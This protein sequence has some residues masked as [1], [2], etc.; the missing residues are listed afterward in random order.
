MIARDDANKDENDELDDGLAH[1]HFS[2]FAFHLIALVSSSLRVELPSFRLERW[3]R[4][5]LKSEKISKNKNKNAR[6]RS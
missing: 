4:S 1:N 5:T 6:I 3:R 2:S